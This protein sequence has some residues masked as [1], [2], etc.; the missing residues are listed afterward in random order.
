MT[1]S[2][3]GQRGAVL[4]PPL[5][6]TTGNDRDRRFWRPTR[7]PEQIETEQFWQTNIDY[8]HANAVRKGLVARVLA[9]L[10]GE[11]LAL[12]SEARER[13]RA[14]GRGVVSRSGRHDAAQE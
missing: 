9:I 6:S 4:L 10:V 13:C 11:L 8:L 14:D 7:H 1:D 2:T 3:N 12:R 5:F